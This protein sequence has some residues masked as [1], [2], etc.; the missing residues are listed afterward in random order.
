MRKTL[1]VR[2]IEAM[3]A[4]PP[5]GR[6]F[7]YDDKVGGFAVRCTDG[8]CKTYVLVRRFGSK[9]AT[10][11]A[12]GKVGQVSLEWARK[13]AQEWNQ[14]LAEGRDLQAEQAETFKAVSESYMDREGRNLRTASERYSILEKVYPVLG[15]RPCSQ[16][17]RGEIV[18]LLDQIE[19]TRGREAAHRTLMVIN[20]I[21]G[22]H[23]ARS[24]TF[25][26]PIVKGMGRTAGNK[27]QRVLDDQ[28]LR[29]LWAATAKGELPGEIIFGA[30]VR[31]LILTALR[32]NEAA[33]LKRSELVNGDLIIPPE[34]YKTGLELV[35]P[36]SRAARE[37][38]EALPGD[39]YLFTTDGGRTHLQGFGKLKAKLEAELGFEFWLHDLRRTS[40]SLLS[41][42]GVNADIA[43]RALGH[44]IGGVRGVYDRYNFH[45]E[46]QVA[47]EKLATLIES[48]VNPSENVVHLSQP[49]AT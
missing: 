8:G 23:A 4:P 10:A 33:G 38:I 16:I 17:R 34:R 39:G 27:R 45:R 2:S 3:K 6:A 47:F 25:V 12:I 28:E 29:S 36:L 31:F 48:I 26:N 18:T 24:D 41:R 40:R 5:G 9:N 30:F 44:V 14:A 49:I 42:A 35:I 43:E 1:T 11:R 46:K 19:A 37:I 20:K 7:L 32:R 15:N 21:L 22:W 13:R